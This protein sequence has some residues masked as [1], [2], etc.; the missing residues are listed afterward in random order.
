MR[1]AESSRRGAKRELGSWVELLIV[2]VPFAWALFWIVFRLRPVHM[3]D[4]FAYLWNAPVS[5]AFFTGRALSVRV[6]YS[7][8][9]NHPQTIVVV[10]LAIACAV[11]VCI[12]L[13]VRSRAQTRANLLTAATL[14]LAA[15]SFNYSLICLALGS[16]PLFL[17]LLTLFPFVLVLGRGRARPLLVLA[18][19]IA[20]IFSHNTAPAIVLTALVAYAA[21]RGRRVSMESAS[22]ATRAELVALP[23]LGAVAIAASVITQ[24][25]DTSVEINAAN[26]VFARVLPDERLAAHFHERHGMPRGDYLEQLRGRN[27]LATLDGRPIFRT[28]P[29][30]RNYELVPDRY[31]FLTWVKERGFREYWKHRLLHE[32]V[33]TLVELRRALRELYGSSTV[34]FWS[35]HVH[36][37]AVDRAVA[38]RNEA[39]L[40][41]D[42][43]PDASVFDENYYLAANPDVAA[44]VGRGEIASA[45]AH[46]DRYGRGE[47][48]LPGRS[49]RH[50]AGAVGPPPAGLLGFDPI[51]LASRLFAA[52]GL[53]RLELLS[54]LTL[55]CLAAARWRP[56]RRAPAIAFVLLTGGLAG[57]FLGYFADALDLAR[58]VWAATLMLTLGLACAAVAALDAARGRLSPPT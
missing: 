30:T 41:G 24:S 20:L 45:R 54:L 49:D 47:G 18:A 25:R 16:D 7:L 44:A 23:L 36:S 15:T 37:H 50:E 57:F 9:A 51:A 32:P 12:Q 46:Y 5:A 56:D 43:D 13:L 17:C 27:V 52:V 14:A 1:L 34:T 39:A 22:S 21:L 10:Q 11:A 35:A 55:A 3:H 8:C 4:S 48:R 6:V 26:N 19:G 33:A 31:G 53:S 28:N 29:D 38:A 58:H 40:R 42:L 2:S